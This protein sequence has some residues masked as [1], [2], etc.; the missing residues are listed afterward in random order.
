MQ[1]VRDRQRKRE[2]S[3]S[4]VTWQ[5]KLLLTNGKLTLGPA[6]AACCCEEPPLE[7]CPCGPWTGV[8]SLHAEFDQ[9]FS[10]T[11]LALVSSSNDGTNYQA[12]WQGTS[13]GCTIT[14]ICS[15]QKEENGVWQWGTSFQINSCILTGTTNP[16]P[17]ATGTVT[18]SVTIADDY[19]EC[20]SNQ[21][22]SVT[23][24]ATPPAGCD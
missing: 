12:M 17:D 2:L 3:M 7:E 10:A 8:A 4:L 20:C 6:S 5:G 16:I 18:F 22:I 21:T 13:I 14:V 11:D 9:C 15:G 19:C 24:S 23:L 1:S